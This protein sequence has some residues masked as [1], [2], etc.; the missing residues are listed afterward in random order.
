MPSDLLVIILPVKSDDQIDDRWQLLK[1][2]FLNKE[3][4]FNYENELEFLT[5]R[6][7]N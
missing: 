5:H 3:R 2:F 7:Y 1:I 6:I 4:T